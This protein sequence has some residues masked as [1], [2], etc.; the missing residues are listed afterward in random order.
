M[1]RW[2]AHDG[3]GEL[4]DRFEREDADRTSESYQHG[5]LVFA[6]ESRGSRVE[7]V[8]CNVYDLSPDTVGVFDLVFCAS[9]LIHIT[10]PLRA[11]AA[12]LVTDRSNGTRH[13]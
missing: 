9:M 10:D 12:G 1:L 8:F 4:K 5:A 13:I 2:S 11:R 7:Q 3:S 6:I